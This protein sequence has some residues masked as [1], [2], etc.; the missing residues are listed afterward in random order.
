MKGKQFV[1][2]PMDGMTH[3]AFRQ[4]CFDYGA[5]GATT[6]MVSAV[7]YGRAKKR[8]EAFEETLVR[9]PGEGNLAVQLIGSLPEDMAVSAQRIT[10][11]NKFDAIDINMGCPARTVVGSGNGSALLL[12]PARAME[13]MQAVKENTTL[14]VRLK[15]RLGWDENHIVADEL[16]KAAGQM[17][18]ES[19]TL[20]GRTRLQMYTG[21]VDAGAIRRVC[22]QAN[23]PVFANGGATKAEDALSF[24]EETGASGVSI[25]RAALKQPWIFDDIRRL[26]RGEAIPERPAAERTG[27]LLRMARILCA[28]RPEKFAINEMRKFSI[29]MIKGLSGGNEVL[30]KICNVDTLADYENVL[31]D[32]LNGLE[33]VGDIYIHPELAEVIT[34]DTVRN[35]VK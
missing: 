7:S 21:D 4:I 6:E 35:P 8:R 22:E 3:A 2:A 27:I 11:L 31:E 18:F 9:L 16:A 17:G 15:L 30:E 20:H 24:L 34:L 1:L 13:V 26:Q 33:R 14:P 23:I 28:M 32:Y 5:D 19:I 10:E 25:G 29:W 12:D